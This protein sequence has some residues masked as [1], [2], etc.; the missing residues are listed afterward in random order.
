MTAS[1]AL[2]VPANPLIGR[3][4]EITALKAILSNA[5]IRLITLTGPGGVGK[6]RLATHVAHDLQDAFADG[7]WFVDL[8]PVSD[9]AA[10]PAAIARALGLEFGTSSQTV[11][12]RALRHQQTLILLDNFEQVIDAAPFIAQLLAAAPRLTLLVTSRAPLRLTIEQ[13]FEV[14]PLALPPAQPTQPTQP[15]DAFAA[16]QLF[17]QRARA[18]QPQFVLTSENEATVAA[19]CRRLDGLPLAIELAA[20]G[21]RTLTPAALLRRLDQHLPIAAEGPRD[22]P[23]R[24]QTLHATLDWSRQ[25]LSAPAQRVFAQMGVFVGGATLD[26]IDAV[27]DADGDVLPHVHA[28]VEHSLIRHEETAGE[29]RYTMLETIRAYALEQ[30][31]ASGEE[32]IVR[33]RHAAFFLQLAEASVPHLRT[34]QQVRWLDALEADHDNLRAA[35]DWLLQSGD[36]ESALRLAGALHWF[37]DRRGYLDEGRA[38]MHAALSA[39]A[40]VDSPSVDLQR[41]RA[42]ALAGAAALAFDQGDRDAVSA[43]AAQS[44]A[45]FRQ[46]GD[47][48]GLVLASLRLAFARQ[49]SDPQAAGALLNEA[50]ALAQAAESSWFIALA[51]FV[52]AQAALFGAHD[53]ALALARIREAIRALD[54]DGD[55]WLLAHCRGIQGLALLAAGD[56]AAARDSLEHGLA[57][58]RTLNDRRSVALLAATTADVARCQADYPRASELYGESLALYQQLGNHA[59]LPALLHNQGYVALGMGDGATARALFIESLHRQHA[60]GNVAG[61]AEGLHGLAA[62]AVAGKQLD[63]AAKLMGAAEAMRAANP[64]PVWPAELHEN[65]RHLDAL[66]GL[67]PASRFTSLWREGEAMG[68]EQAMAVALDDE[69]ALAH[70]SAS[71]AGSLSAREREIAALIAQGASNHAIAERLVISERTVERHISN[72]FAKLDFGSRTQIVR[73]AIENGLAR[74]A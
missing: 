68:M 15:I 34:A 13:T 41:A 10:V 11:L 72:I 45:L 70:K 55:P 49:A 38:R 3:A 60:A 25:R 23:A 69:E 56:L 42:W 48:E 51:L 50:L 17:V 71:R 57:T 5:E 1:I 18:I 64:A 4:Q 33:A 7:V 63:H 67:L 65:R 12:L 20:Q 26:A 62:V 19:I 28:L 66:R 40:K 47:N 31:A 2:P 35:G 6:T 16:V 30:L 36:V 58:A 37:W 53:V 21:L 27:C 32:S 9:A 59:E 44:A 61:V 43:L 73:F 46:A 22:L 54:E 8:A 14:A 39:A 29:S 74:R 24:Q 52:A